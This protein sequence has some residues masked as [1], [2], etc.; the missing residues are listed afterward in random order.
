M[1]RFRRAS[2]WLV[3]G[4][5][6]L[7]IVGCSEKGVE[8]KSP[9]PETTTTA[10]IAEITGEIDLLG[11]D[12]SENTSESSE[13]GALTK[14]QIQSMEN[15]YLESENVFQIVSVMTVGG[16]SI[17]MGK[18]MKGSFSK[19]QIVEYID[20]F[21]QLRKTC[22]SMVESTDSQE[23]VDTS[24][25]TAGLSVTGKALKMGLTS[26]LFKRENYKGLFFTIPVDSNSQLAY[27]DFFAE[28]KTFSVQ[29]DNE[30][31]EVE[32]VSYGLS[33]DHISMDVVVIFDKDYSF[34]VL[35]R[36]SVTGLKAD[37]FMA[38]QAT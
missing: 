1:K 11:T 36:I 21:G 10:T 34:E 33:Q 15:Q 5:L 8:T 7:T 29:I 3:S 6:M 31:Y 23:K 4:V 38:A 16:S 32:L 28:H 37:G 35:K 17:V 14:A 20:K 18:P 19:N 25:R 13:D 24:V 30:A 26:Y 9:E 27:E 22:I 2:A 12:G